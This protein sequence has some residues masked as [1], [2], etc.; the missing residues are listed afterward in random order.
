MSDRNA[1]Q[2]VA[3]YL[4]NHLAPKVVQMA[5]AR[6][7]DPLRYAAYITARAGEDIQDIPVNE[8]CSIGGNQLFYDDRRLRVGFRGRRLAQYLI[9]HAGSTLTHEELMK[10]VWEGARF[11]TS[12][13]R[14][15]V[16]K[17]RQAIGPEGPN[18]IQTVQSVGYRLNQLPPAS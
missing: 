9:R 18:L 5:R 4:A 10:H 8:L 2:A 3:N 16:H 14:V 6:G 11:S 17:L 15:Q 13:L 12:V 1:E 7:K